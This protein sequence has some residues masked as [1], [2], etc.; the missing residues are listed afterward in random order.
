[1]RWTWGVA[2][3][4]VG[5]TLCVAQP[6]F[7]QDDEESSSEG[8]AATGSLQRSNRMEFDARLI[9]GETAGSGAV[10][11]FQRA[12]RKLPS[13]VPRR[14]SYLRDSVDETLGDRGSV[15]FDASKA[16]AIKEAARVEERKKK[17][18]S[19]SSKRS[20]KSKKRRSR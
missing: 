17:R 20:K 10:F 1:M 2:A 3:A 8:E 18:N 15:S 16:K 14:T 11:I 5:A 7:A 4:L 19:R 9:R 6:A 13:M 12:P